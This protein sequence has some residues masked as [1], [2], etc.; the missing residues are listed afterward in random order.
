[1]VINY[2]TDK[3]KAAAEAVILAIRASNPE[4]NT[5][6]V[7][8]NIS[9]SNGRQKLVDAAVAAR[10]GRKI[11][12][13]VHNADNGDDRYLEDLDE[14]FFDMQMGLNVKG[15]TKRDRYSLS[16]AN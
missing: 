2:S 6:A 8:T 16:T 5:V 10:A 11:D 1:V 15:D 13:L 9:S 7:Q 3:S 14:D 4:A 12:I